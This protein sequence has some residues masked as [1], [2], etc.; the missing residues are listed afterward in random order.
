MLFWKVVAGELAKAEE[1]GVFRD[2]FKTHAAAE[3]L[4]KHVVGV[5]HG[6][7]EVHVLAAADLEHGFAGNDVF[8]E[9]G[10][11]DGRLDRGA[12]NVAVTKCNFLIDYRKNSAGVGIDGDDGAVVAAESLDGGFADDGVV[13]GGDVGARGV[14][15]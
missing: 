14:G 12:R 1:A 13:K 11:G 9:G 6:L 15:K 8:L 3:L 5:S 10:D 2:G 7:G 4:E